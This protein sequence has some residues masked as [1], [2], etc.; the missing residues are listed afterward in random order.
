MPIEPPMATHHVLATRIRPGRFNVYVGGILLA[1]DTAT[2]FA[3]AARAMLR[4]SRAKPDDVMVCK[5]SGAP[6]P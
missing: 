6:R 5:I 4:E 1:G 2:P 3:D